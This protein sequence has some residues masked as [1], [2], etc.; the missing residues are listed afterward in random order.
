VG[1][2]AGVFTQAKAP[3]V[4]EGGV[5]EGPQ[6]GDGDLGVGEV[7][8]DDLVDTLESESDNTMEVSLLGLAY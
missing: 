6:G 1:D 7:G 4:V 5:S 3:G 2:F 8:V